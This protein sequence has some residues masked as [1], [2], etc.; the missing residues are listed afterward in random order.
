MPAGTDDVLDRAESL[1]GQQQVDFLLGEAKK[2]GGP[3][4]LYTSYSADSLGY[5]YVS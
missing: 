4:R 3:L 1:N 2:E 5:C